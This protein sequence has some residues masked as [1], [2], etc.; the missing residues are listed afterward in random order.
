LRY[1]ARYAHFLEELTGLFVRLVVAY[2]R[3]ARRL[4][5]AAHDAFEEAR[6]RLLEPGGGEQLVTRRAIALALGECPQQRAARPLGS[7]LDRELVAQAP[8]LQHRSVSRGEHREP[9]GER[10]GG[11]LRAG[12]Q[13]LEYRRHLLLTSS[14]RREPVPSLPACLLHPPAVLLGR[15]PFRTRE[16]HS[17]LNRRAL[18]E[19]RSDERCEIRKLPSCRAHGATR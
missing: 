19:E 3:Q 16:E 2:R 11:L 18:A 10:P 8:P 7:R 14:R 9:V 1:S 6:V 12:R 13:L 17:P 4:G 5:P 15:E